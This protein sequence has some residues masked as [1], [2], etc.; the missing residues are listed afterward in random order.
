V[1]VIRFYRGDFNAPSFDVTDDAYSAIGSL[2][3]SDVQNVGGLCLDLLAWAEDLR[4][5]RLEHQ[6]WHGNSW[7]AEMTPQG[8]ALS[9]LYSDDWQGN[10]SLSEAHEV[11][12][13]Y[14]NFLSPTND[15]KSREM[16]EWESEFG[17]VHPCRPHL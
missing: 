11:M 8:V 9:D 17:R 16:A 5:G 14:W 12:L 4:A 3:T 7:A 6:S 15:E 13:T 2:M 10:Y 1:S